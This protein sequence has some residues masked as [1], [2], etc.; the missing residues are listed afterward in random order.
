MPHLSSAYELGQALG[1]G[2]HATVFR[3][4]ARMNS[5]DANSSREDVAVKVFHL[6]T[7]QALA[8][9]ELRLLTVAQGHPNVVRLVEYIDDVWP[10]AIVLELCGRDLE[11]LVSKRK[12]PLPEKKAVK[13]MGDVVAALKHVHGLDIVHRDVKPE[14][15][16]IGMDGKARLMDFGIA[17]SSSDELE[18]CT[19][20]GS[21]GYTAPEILSKKP[22]S[23]PVDVFAAGVTLYFV[24]S[25]QHAFKTPNMSN[26]SIIARTKWGV[27]SFGDMFD[28]V[29]DDTKQMI[30]LC[31]HRSPSSRPTACVA[32]SASPF[33]SS[34]GSRIDDADVNATLDAWSPALP[35]MEQRLL[36]TTTDDAARLTHEARARQVINGQASSSSTVAVVEKPS[37]V[38]AKGASSDD[39]VQMRR[40]L[41]WQRQQ[42]SPPFEAQVGMSQPTTKAFLS[43]VGD[44]QDSSLSSGGQAGVLLARKS[45]RAP[46]VGDVEVQKPSSSQV[47]Q[48]SPPLLAWAR[49]ARPA[50][51][52][53]VRQLSRTDATSEALSH[54]KTEAPSVESVHPAAPLVQQA[55][56]P[57]E[58]RARPARPAPKARVRQVSDGQ[59]SL[60]VAT[61]VEPPSDV[62]SPQSVKGVD[63]KHPDASLQ[64]QTASPPFESIVGVA[65]PASGAWECKSHA[66]KASLSPTSAAEDTFDRRSTAASSGDAF[67]MLHDD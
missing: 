25:K 61:V 13:F 50:P 49:T 44:C 40:L 58:P 46:S 56:A 48:A 24:L 17:V 34:V 60:P 20:R 55:S 59:T 18:L 51:K 36:S 23:F 35:V 19:P 47:L 29:S 52:A 22:Y 33:A 11:T 1:D 28:H 57:L 67:D 8:R 38:H 41:P 27:I 39:E 21:L 9:S 53:R 65:Q 45:E 3:A 31:S 10:H 2:A 6:H 54:N 26:E 30:L 32:L 42:A 14:N 15:V 16:A 37:D 4:T 62:E 7:A 64:Q 66:K 43:Q 12:R 63:L 5:D